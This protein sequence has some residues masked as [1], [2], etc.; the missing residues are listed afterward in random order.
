LPGDRHRVGAAM[1]LKDELGPIV[2]AYN[3]YVRRKLEWSVCWQCSAETG[4]ITY[5][6]D[7]RVVITQN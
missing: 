7:N 2:L 1:I 3:P 4:F 5:R 6:E